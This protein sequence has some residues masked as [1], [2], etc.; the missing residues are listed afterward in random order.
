MVRVLRLTFR[1]R[2]VRPSTSVRHRANSE[3][4]LYDYQLA[5]RK[6]VRVSLL[7]KKFDEWTIGVE[8]IG[9]KMLPPS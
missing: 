2:P 3:P 5:R 4:H 1:V 9:A 7:Q 6:F 8:V